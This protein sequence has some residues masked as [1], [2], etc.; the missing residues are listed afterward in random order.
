MNTTTV[1]TALIASFAGGALLAQDPNMEDAIAAGGCLACGGTMLMIPIVILAINIGLLV[2]V[3]R[4]SKARGLDNSVGWILLV[5][6]TSVIGLVVYLLSRPQ[7]AL[8]ACSH[9]GNKRLE[10]SAQCPYCGNA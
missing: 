8:V 10:T 6:F 1:R 5:L 7:G 3:A 4:D 9:C 2:W